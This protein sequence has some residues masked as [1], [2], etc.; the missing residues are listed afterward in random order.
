L[1][2]LLLFDQYISGAAVR[3]PQ[4]QKWFFVLA[5]LSMAMNYY[6]NILTHQLGRNPILYQEIDPTYWLFMIAG[7]PDLITGKAAI[8]FDLILV[9]SCL[10]GIIWNKRSWPAWIFGIFHFV[11]FILYNMMS[12]HH[13]AN[14][15]L[16][17]VGFAFLFSNN[18]RFAYALTFCRFL[19]CFMMLSAGLWK[20]FRGGLW[21]PDQIHSLLIS[22]NLYSLLENANS[23]RM[24]IINFLIQHKIVA[25]FL[26]VLMII[27]ELI[28]VIGFITIKR[29][30]LLFLAF[31]LFVFGG[32]YFF[33][34]FNFE[35]L[36]FFL[37]LYPLVVPVRTSWF[38]F[39]AKQQ[40][41][42]SPP[43]AA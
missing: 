10:A 21:Y 14:I 35:N 31:A 1:T 19:F 8:A 43:T 27:L 32:W 36:A 24:D 42:Q 29:D 38:P 17:M 30:T 41:T 9:G 37:T 34:I 15:G 33:H 28:F 16:L 3:R 7:I 20:I 11:Y 6:F 40:R 2:P 23:W 5:L 4:L 39:L 26:W 18:Q 22:H 25:H 12:G 13:Y